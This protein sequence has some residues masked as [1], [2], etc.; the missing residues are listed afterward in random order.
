M[1]LEAPNTLPNGIS[2]LSNT[3]VE[4]FLR[5]Q[6][7]WRKTYL[8]KV[9]QP[10]WSGMILG[11]A[12]H[13]ACT[14]SYASQIE[15]GVPHS[16]EQVLDDFK[17][18]LD[19]EQASE[20]EIAWEDDDAPGRILEQGINT[21]RSYHAFIP[22]IMKPVKVET[23]FKIRLHAD[24]QWTVNGF[25]DLV[26]STD[27]GLIQTPEAPHDLKT[28]K[29][30]M[31]QGDLDKSLQGSIYTYATMREDETSRNFMV[32]EMKQNEARVVATPR[33]R[34]DGERAMELIAAVARQIDRNIQT[35]DW[36][37]ASAWA[38]WCSPSKCGYFA[39]C[40][41]VPHG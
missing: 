13:A 21:L 28:A 16:M 41:K 30:K 29:K 4:L 3:S 40:P 31:P 39:D 38:W 34:E 24:H 25:I 12:V 6:E 32:H 7:S 35:G 10:P 22:R 27:D 19:N 2:S 33:T 36:Q 37:G 18:T 1:N 15:T 5:C 9:Y 23:K 11:R 8:E 20:Q 26:A 17:T 14:Q